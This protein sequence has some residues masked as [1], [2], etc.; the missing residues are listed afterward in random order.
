MEKNNFGK[1]I[2]IAF[3]IEVL[4]ACIIGRTNPD[5][6]LNVI[7]LLLPFGFLILF[8]RSIQ[9][10]L[11]KKAPFLINVTALVAVLYSAPRFIDIIM[12]V[13]PSSIVEL[14]YD[15]KSP[16]FI[17]NKRMNI[18]HETGK[19]VIELIEGGANN[20][21]KIYFPYKIHEVELF[22]TSY[23]RDGKHVG[24]YQWTEEEDFTIH[25]DFIESHH[26]LNENYN[27]WKGRH[28]L[29]YKYRL[30]LI[31]FL[32]NSSRHYKSLFKT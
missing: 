22:S 17:K 10:V 11:S 27:Q 8:F 23:D 32:R 5:R 30:S 6:M 7:I 15:L 31:E 18:N 26:Y 24:R 21:Y 1:F 2:I 9:D 13:V 14:H 20:R 16:E 25:G 28:K 3:L 4:V 29:K 12:P 19:Y